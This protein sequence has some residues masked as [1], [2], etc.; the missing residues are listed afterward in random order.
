MSEETWWKQSQAPALLVRREAEQRLA[1]LANDAALLWAREHEFDATELDRLAA[2]VGA[3]GQEH[4]DGALGRTP[5][6]RGDMIWHAVPCTEGWLVWCMT[7]Q[8]R[9]EP[10]EA[11]VARADILRL[12]GRIGTIVGDTGA[13]TAAWDAKACHLWGIDPAVPHPSLRELL[14]WVHPDDRQRVEA[15]LTQRLHAPGGANERFRLRTRDGGVRHLHALLKPQKV[16]DLQPD[17]L[18]GVIV[19]DTETIE[20]YLAQRKVADQA[21]SALE[22]AGVGVWHQSLSSGK[23]FGDGVY[24]ERMQVGDDRTEIDHEWVMAQHHPDDRQAARDAN[25]RAL[26]SKQIVDAVLRVAGAD[27]AGYRTLLTRRIAQRDP[28][29]RPVELVGVSMDISALVRVNEQAQAWARRAE[30]AAAASGVGFWYLDAASGE[31]EW[32][33]AMFA[34]H[35]RDP[36]LGTPSWHDWL[37]EAVE[38]ADRSALQSALQSA[39]RL[40]ANAEP[41]HERCR[42]SDGRGGE[43]WVSVTLQPE[44]RHNPRHWIVM[45]ADIT[46]KL[47]SG[48]ALRLE[49]QRARFAAE[50]ANLGLWECSDDA[51]PLYLNETM[52]ALLGL[53]P[54]PQQRSLQELW[55]SVRPVAERERLEH[56]IRLHALRRD[57]LEHEMHVIWPDGSVHWIALR[58][59]SLS[60]E[61]GQP[62]QMHGVGWDVTALRAAKLAHSETQAALDEAR[63]RMALTIQLR[64]ELRSALTP[65]I[66]LGE[67]VAASPEAPAH[68]REWLAIVRA[69]GVELTR[70]LDALQQGS[71]PS[72]L[73]TPLLQSETPT[74]AANALTP[75]LAIGV[76]CVQN[77][78]LSLSLLENLVAS[79]RH[80]KLEAAL[81]VALG[82]QAV[83]KLQPQLVLVDLRLPDQAAYELLRRVRGDPALA[84]TLCV[85]VSPSAALNEIEQALDAGFD[86]CWPQPIKVRP[87][88]A[89]LDALAAGRSLPKPAR[90]PVLH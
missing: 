68:V 61:P 7:A 44:S 51:V 75:P 34:L 59:R 81:N 70:Q 88:L 47:A 43:R 16:E 57:T 25:A 82:L 48:A 20:R 85:A 13:G 15:L 10:V 24:R 53:R 19:D 73:T 8:T 23:V 67:L 17:E 1:W 3:L 29:G 2:D 28:N 31:G 38:S 30:L 58:A 72:R 80:V 27:E 71:A 84:T 60:I 50:A 32:D 62:E 14:A 22:L 63:A 65:L 66:G 69:T 4:V 79:R 64:R 11:P 21:L 45:L 12:F 37:D 77:D 40:A 87:F 41:C 83:R 33:R 55:A 56:S 6:R 52:L 86:D 26:L 39:L 18:A 74:A 9:P 76:V 5:A 46:E 54:T 90:L 78:P 42:I 35:G 49:Q 36:D 89:A